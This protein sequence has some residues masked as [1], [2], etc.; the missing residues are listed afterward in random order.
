MV[1]KI[2]LYRLIRCRPQS[3]HD[4]VRLLPWQRGMPEWFSDAL[5]W[6]TLGKSCTALTRFSFRNHDW[7]HHVPC[8]AVKPVVDFPTPFVSLRTICLF[9]FLIY[10]WISYSAS[11][12]FF[13]FELSRSLRYSYIIIFISLWHNITLLDPFH[14]DIIL[15]Y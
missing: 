7:H 10:T 3:Y 11:S 6:S 15:N 1:I 8:F 12:F 5:A 13:Y 4:F 2:L 14:Y 9:F